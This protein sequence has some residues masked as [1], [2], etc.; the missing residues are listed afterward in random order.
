M[1][2]HQRRTRKVVLGARSLNPDQEAIPTVARLFGKPGSL[3][4]LVAAWSILSP[5]SLLASVDTS[6]AFSVSRS[7]WSARTLGTEREAAPAATVPYRD[8]VTRSI[9][10][11]SDYVSFGGV[12]TL[13]PPIGRQFQGRGDFFYQAFQRGVLQWRPDLKR[14]VPANTL[15]KVRS[16][17]GVG[18]I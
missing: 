3:L 2:D 17:L 7:A 18:M 12:D 10:L 14:S 9:G 1:A 11:W 15:P 16:T 6:H 8:F 4:T 13:G 5:S